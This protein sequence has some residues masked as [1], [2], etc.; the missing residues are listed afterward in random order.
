MKTVYLSILISIFYI[1][2]NAQQ[3]EWARSLGGSS[4]ER[5]YSITTDL[6]GN[7]I[8]TGLFEGSVD[9]DPGV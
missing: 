3:F 6:S 8:S 5:G 7:V 9:F 1:S 2:M 4:F